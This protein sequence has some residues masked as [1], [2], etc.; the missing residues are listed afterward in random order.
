MEPLSLNIIHPTPCLQGLKKLPAGSV[1]T[2]ITSPPYWLLRDYGHDGQLGTERTP[3]AFIR[4]LRAIFDQVNRVMRPHGTLWIVIG[5]SFL[6]SGR[7]Y[8]GATKGP[9]GIPW[10]L[11]QALRKSGWHLNQEIIW[12][13]A[14]STNTEN[15]GS[16]MPES[17][18]NRFVKSHEHI[19][20]LSKSP[21]YFFDLE[22]I[23]KPIREVSSKRLQ[24]NVEQQ[25][26]SDRVP[27]KSNGT[28]KA[29][30]G[31]PQMARSGSNIPGHSGD[32]QAGF[33]AN[34]R[35]V[36]YYL[37][38]RT[39]EAHFATYPQDLIMD[40][41]KAATSE[42]GHCATCGVPWTR[43]TQIIG[44]V[45]AHYG[46]Q[47]KAQQLVTQ[48]RGASSLDKSMLTT[49]QLPV[50][51]TTGWTAGCKCGGG[52]ARKDSARYCTGSIHG[53]RHYSHYGQEAKP[54]LHRL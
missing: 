20:L 14:C 52:G 10:M 7:K 32:I 36:W 6:G 46:N 22:A 49:N 42:H 45:K 1:D 41:I 17:V 48:Q 53:R 30:V 31:A 11:A 18:K 25:K 44:H 26:G 5:D 28:M 38:A 19:F 50:K 33:T 12:A 21:S 4:K 2:C 34:K 54:Q 15:F 27:G 47:D 23:K 29:V 24:Q 3:Q 40:F 43:T 16:V 37:P 9:V 8:N 13:K 39:S 51:E 35:S